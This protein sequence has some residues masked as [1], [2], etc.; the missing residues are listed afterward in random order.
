MWIR[1][2]DRD[3]LINLDKVK[4]IFMTIT[5]FR[6]EIKADDITLGVYTSKNNAIDTLAY[7]HDCI[8]L[9]KNEMFMPIEE[10]GELV[11]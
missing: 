7:I 3:K 8:Y 6:Y 5:N 2:Q 9:G 11:K 1:S 10:N 4:T